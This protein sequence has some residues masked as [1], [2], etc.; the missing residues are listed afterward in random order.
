MPIS[1]VYLVDGYRHELYHLIYALLSLLSTT[2]SAGTLGLSYMELLPFLR[3]TPHI[4]L[5]DLPAITENVLLF[6][7]ASFTW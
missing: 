6:P 5:F 4:S 1:L 2:H 3:Q 7:L